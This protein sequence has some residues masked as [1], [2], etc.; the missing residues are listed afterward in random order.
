MLCEG[1]KPCGI[2]GAQAPLAGRANVLPGV[3]MSTPG[4]K[5]GGVRRSE[6]LIPASMAW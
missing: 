1:R 4:T 6:R 3:T 2:H 5:G